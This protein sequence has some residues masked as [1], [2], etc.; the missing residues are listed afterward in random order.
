M[1]LSSMLC[2]PLWV[3]IKVWKTEGTLPE[4]SSLGGGVRKGGSEVG[5]TAQGRAG[6]AGRTGACGHSHGHVWV[7]A[8]S[9]GQWV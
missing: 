9:S 1:A 4:V 6:S 3:F 8:S 7:P 2:I 5:G